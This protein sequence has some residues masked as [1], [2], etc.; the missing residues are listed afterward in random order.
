MMTSLQNTEMLQVNYAFFDYLPSYSATI[1]RE[2][3]PALTTS[4][5][6]DSIPAYPVPHNHWHPLQ[7]NT[8]N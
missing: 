1:A 3:L 7:K 4:Y 2:D 8:K 5:F 6:H